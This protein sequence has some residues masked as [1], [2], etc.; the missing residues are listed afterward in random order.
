M[1]GSPAEPKQCFVLFF[2]NVVILFFLLF[3][4]LLVVSVSLSLSQTNNDYGTVNK[5]NGLGGKRTTATLS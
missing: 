4:Y 1:D 3:I 5:N 2:G